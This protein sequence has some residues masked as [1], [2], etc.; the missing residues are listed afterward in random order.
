[1]RNLPQV[2]GYEK[3]SSAQ[4]AGPPFGR[5]LEW[6]EKDTDMEVEVIVANDVPE[7][8]TVQVGSFGGFKAVVTTYVCS[9][10]GLPRVGNVWLPLRTLHDRS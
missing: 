4:L 7:H 8:D 2:Y 9:N 10:D 6:S 1:M 3:S 5:Y